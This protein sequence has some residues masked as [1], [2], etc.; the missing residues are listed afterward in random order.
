MRQRLSL[1]GLP[2]LDGLDAFGDSFREGDEAA[3][4]DTVLGDAAVGDGAE[5]A[6]A[7]E[8]GAAVGAAGSGMSKA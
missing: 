7:G 5:E 2:T 3:A 4:G 6:T 8:R 1:L